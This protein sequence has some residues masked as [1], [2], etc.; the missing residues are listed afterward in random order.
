MI[1]NLFLLYFAPFY[2]KYKLKIS[3]FIL[4]NI[5]WKKDTGDLNSD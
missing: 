1:R 3:F 5:D 2:G 4:K